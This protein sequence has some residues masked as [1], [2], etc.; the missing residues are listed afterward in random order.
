[1]LWRDLAKKGTGDK[2]SHEHFKSRLE[3]IHSY[4]YYTNAGAFLG[5]YIQPIASKSPIRFWVKDFYIA[6]SNSLLYFATPETPDIT[7]LF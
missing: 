7:A 3:I 5:A 1:M 4:A 6:S 2:S